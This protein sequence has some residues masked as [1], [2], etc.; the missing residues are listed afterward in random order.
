MPFFYLR[1]DPP[2]A[3]FLADMSD[4]ERALMGAHL[5]HWRPHVE[6]GLV[7]AMGPVAAR[8]GGFG[9]LIADA[10]SLE[11]LEAITGHDPVILAQCGFRYDMASMPNVLLRDGAPK[12]ARPD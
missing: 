8:D 12:H 6:S 11:Q 9:V 3:T 5:T 7:V 1:L 4:D 10:P 2:R